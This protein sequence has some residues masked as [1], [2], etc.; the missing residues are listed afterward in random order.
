MS[1]PQ[2]VAHAHTSTSATNL[3]P[4]PTSEASA[5]Q[6]NAPRPASANLPD[7]P[8]GVHAPA[9]EHGT[10][11]ATDASSPLTLNEKLNAADRYWKFKAGLYALLIIAGIIGIGCFGWIRAKTRFSDILY[12][13]DSTG[14]TWPCLITFTISIIWSA[15]CILVFVGRKRAVHPGVRV[16]MDL[17]LW[18]AYIVTI[19][20]AML[21][22]YSIIQFGQYGAINSEKIPSSSSSGYFLAE[23]N[24]WVW[25]QSSDPDYA[26]QRSCSGYSYSSSSFDSTTCAE[27]DAE[28]NALWHSKAHRLHVAL[29]GVVCQFL[30]L[31]LHFT[32]F[33]WACVDTHYYNR[34]KVSK[35]AEKLA[36]GIVQTMIVN[37]AILPPPGQAHL[38]Q[39][40]MGHGAT[41]QP[42]YHQ[43]SGQQGQGMHPMGMQNNGQAMHMPPA[44]YHAGTPV[45]TSAM[46]IAPA[47]PSGEKGQAARYA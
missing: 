23:N 11:A 31:V 44:Q 10:P 1:T 7:A 9:L 8:N 40:R 4:V 5:P 46:A 47:G 38:P 41:A 18:L 37:G 33:V 15:I 16:S 20:F 12:F 27:Q 13:S 22:L 30:C 42:I 35:D 2:N 29:T 45:E 34:T 14:Y 28:L 39:Q 6:Q 43:G 21:G 3:P 24:T 32:L 25:L 17:L 36:A 19:L 26:S